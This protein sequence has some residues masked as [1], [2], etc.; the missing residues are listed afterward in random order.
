MEE[1]IDVLIM[2]VA[3]IRDALCG[4]QEEVEVPSGQRCP[5]VRATGE[6]ISNCPFCK[7]GG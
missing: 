5:C 7:G 2:L 6:P 4:P 3:E 1:K